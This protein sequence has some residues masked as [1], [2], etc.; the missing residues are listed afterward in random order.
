M[1]AFHPFDQLWVSNFKHQTDT[2]LP[3][4]RS[5]FCRAFGLPVPDIDLLTPLSD[6]MFQSS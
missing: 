5:D 6:E 1:R 3:C 2:A 4:N